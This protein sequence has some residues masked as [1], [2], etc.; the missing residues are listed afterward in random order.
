[1]IIIMIGLMWISIVDVDVKKKVK[2]LKKNWKEL[3]L[4]LSESTPIGVPVLRS[5]ARK[6]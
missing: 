3:S 6:I 4:Y 1:M 5:G 2:L